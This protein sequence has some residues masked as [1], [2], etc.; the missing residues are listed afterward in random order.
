MQRTLYEIKEFLGLKPDAADRQQVL[1]DLVSSQREV[2]PGA[3]FYARKG[4]HTDARTLIPEA[5][6]RGA[7][8]V[9]M[10][11]A[12]AEPNFVALCGRVPCLILGKKSDL[13]QLASF[14]FHHPSEKLRLLGVTGTNGK[15]TVTF[16]TA[17]LLE[18]LGKKCYI[19][20]T[21]GCGF[22]G[23]LKKSAN[24][25]LEPIALQRELALA[26]SQGARYA[27]MEVS[28][29]GAAEGRIDGC[30]F[31]GAAFTN[32]TRDHLD[33]HQ[34][35]ENYAEAKF[36]F[37]SRVKPQRV[38]INADDEWGRQF[39]C[40]LDQS[41]YFGSDK[42]LPFITDKRG[43]YAG[44]LSF[45]SNG[46]QFEVVSSLGQIAVKLPLFGAFN[47]SNYM[48]AISLLH[49][50]GLPLPEMLAFSDK[51]KPVVGRMERFAATSGQDLPLCVVDYAHTPDGVEQALKACRQH[52]AGG[53]R[54]ICVLGCGGDRDA[55]KRPLMALK[56]AVFADEVILTMDNP[57]SEDPKAIIDDMLLGVAEARFKVSCVLDRRKAI[58]AAVQSGSAQPGSVVLIAGKG[59]ED[60]Q[61]LKDRTIHFSDREEACRLLG[62]PAP[63][64]LYAK[65]AEDKAADSKDSGK[66]GSETLTAGSREDA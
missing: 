32:L 24:T 16:L 57:R 6:E 55:G 22:L 63:A 2:S 36:S 54:L 60:Y 39:L 28:S 19:L 53:G 11:K 18:S 29:I 12:D 13:A 27:V 46:C 30:S 51:L 20:G 42:S 47:V 37:L 59:H 45:N 52:M 21:L 25:T 56:A 5:L 8:A 58:A 50:V 43:M 34:T 15:T 3:I 31:F 33:Y 64:G 35:M 48:A 65:S 49:A 44:K 17:Q 1:T 14:F 26:V 23:Q 10:D 38:V 62:L 4:L 40:R 61:I 7:G 41:V 9:L 66:D